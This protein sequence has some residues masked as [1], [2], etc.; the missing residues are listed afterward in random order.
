MGSEGTPRTLS[1][2]PLIIRTSP[3]RGKDQKHTWEL[4][5][6]QEEDRDKFWE[7]GCVTTL[8]GDR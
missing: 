3:A 5:A 8:E 4:K 1:V 6:T 7:Q 2:V